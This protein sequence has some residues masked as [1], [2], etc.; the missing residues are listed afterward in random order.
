M[1]QK[2][3]PFC[4]LLNVFSLSSMVVLVVLSDCASKVVGLVV[5]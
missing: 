4:M 3:Q 2:M 5:P 1:A